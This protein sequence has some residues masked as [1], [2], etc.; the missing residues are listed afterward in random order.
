MGLRVTGFGGEGKMVLSFCLLAMVVR[1]K[2]SG[3]AFMLLKAQMIR[4][5]VPTSLN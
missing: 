3:I 2:L 1:R 4:W 5:A